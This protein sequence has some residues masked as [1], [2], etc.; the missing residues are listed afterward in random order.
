M[1]GY[2]K[3]LSLYDYVFG[4]FSEELSEEVVVQKIEARD[5]RQGVKKPRTPKKFPK[6]LD[7]EHVDQHS[8]DLEAHLVGLWELHNYNDLFRYRPQPASL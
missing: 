7:Q 8:Q 6:V 3:T 2:D 5:L 4:R 1:E